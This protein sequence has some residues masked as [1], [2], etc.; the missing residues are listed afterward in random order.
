IG[1]PPTPGIGF[2]AGVER[3]L[4]SLELEGVTAEEQPLDVFLVLEADGD[5]EELLTTLAT[6]RRRGLACDTD[7]A[8]RSLKGQLAHA[9]RRAS[10]VAIRGAGG[11]ALRERGAQ[12]RTGPSLEELL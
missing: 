8:G 2:G 4:L 9:P 6:L 10:K 11:W 1:G 3:L 7:Y 12:D 5:R